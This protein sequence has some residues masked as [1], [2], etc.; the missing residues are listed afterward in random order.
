MKKVYVIYEYQDM[1][2]DSILYV[3][4]DKVKAEKVLE[5]EDDCYAHIEEYENIRGYTNQK[6]IT[7]LEY[8]IK[9]LEKENKRLN[10]FSMKQYGK[11]K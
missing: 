8:K 4:N 3:T 2:D 1:T 9:E 10:M 6:D 7:E 5:I 11:T